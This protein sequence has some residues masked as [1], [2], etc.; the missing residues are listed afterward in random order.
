[1]VTDPIA[2][3]LT[4]IKNGYLARHQT[5]TIPYSRIKEKIGGILVKEGY[6]E[7]QKTEKLKNT[8]TKM[9]VCDL[10]YKNGQPALSQL[11]RFS[12]PG[13][14]VYCHWDNLPWTISGYGI[15]IVSTAKGVMTDKEARKKKLGGEIICQ[16]Y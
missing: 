15:T 2:D 13:K 12:K 10:T 3:M 7:N 8:K 14:R 4:R 5:V 1:M 9:I 11:K 6:L 16:V